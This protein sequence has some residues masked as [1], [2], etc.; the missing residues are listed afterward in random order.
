MP[1][2]PRGPGSDC[3][4]HVLNRAVRRSPLFESPADYAAFEGVLLQ[5]VQ[6]STLRI[7]SY[8]AMPNHW[9]LVLW[10]ATDGDLPRF[11]HWLTGTHAQRWHAIRGT[12]GTGPVYQGRYKAIPVQGDLHVLRIC[13]YV[14]RN[15]LRAGLVPRAE[16]W[17]WSSLW[18]RCNFCTDDFLHDWPIPTPVD[19]T[20]HVNQPQS[21][22]ELHALRWAVQRGAPYGCEEWRTRAAQR[23]G[24]N[25]Q[26]RGPG[27]PASTP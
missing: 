13:R 25:P 4:Y 16:D 14:E 15:P 12:S 23:L 17:R 3:V 2:R 10:P 27:R 11:M 21:A 7:L 1:R 19:W 8:C 5:A 20:E 26:F 6:R 22:T 24:I 9:H 18:R